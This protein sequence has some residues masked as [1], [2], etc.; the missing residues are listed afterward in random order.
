[1]GSRDGGSSAGIVSFSLDFDLQVVAPLLLE[2]AHVDGLFQGVNFE[3]DG[4]A[5]GGSDPLDDKRPRGHFDGFHG[6]T[7]CNMDSVVSL[8]ER[9]CPRHYIAGFKV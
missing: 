3:G 8:K 1:M 7:G 2:D 6:E 5:L 4:G 9:L